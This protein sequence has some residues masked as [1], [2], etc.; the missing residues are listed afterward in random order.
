[1]NITYRIFY[2]FRKIFIIPVSLFL[3]FSY[4]PTVFADAE[5]AQKMGIAVLDFK[6]S[7]VAASESSFVSD[8]FRGALVTA[9]AFRLIDKSNMD[10]VLS[11]Q[12]FQQTGCTSQECAVQMGKLLNVKAMVTGTFGLFLGDYVISI[13]MVDVETGEI[14]YS[15]NKRCK[16]P[17]Q[18]QS[19]VEEMAGNMVA[20]RTGKAV[21]KPA[22]KE[23]APAPEPEPEPQPVY[24]PPVEK[25]VYTPKSTVTKIDGNQVNINLGKKENLRK[26]D[27]LQIYAV[28]QQIK[29]PI[30]GQ[31][32][33]E[34]KDSIAKIK[35]TYLEDYASIGSVISLKPGY[36]LEVGQEVRIPGSESMIR[37]RLDALVDIPAFTTPFFKNPN[38]IYPEYQS[39]LDLNLPVLK[40]SYGRFANNFFVTS[41]RQPMPRYLM[42]SLNSKNFELGFGPA[43][44]TKIGYCGALRFGN[45]ETI[46]GGLDIR[47]WAGNAD[48]TG[49]DY[50]LAA[51]HDRQVKVVATLGGLLTKTA[52]M[53][54]RG[55]MDTGSHN[56]WGESI[57]VPNIGALGLDSI[58]E[59][60]YGLIIDWLVL[61][62][63]EVSIRFGYGL[64]AYIGYWNY[65]GGLSQKQDFMTMLGLAGL[66]INITRNI[67]IGADFEAEL[68]PMLLTDGGGFSPC[69]RTKVDI[70]F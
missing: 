17:G 67:S 68:N 52:G 19:V 6:P 13:G 47:G 2:M 18:I 66:S 38:Y 46:I 22:V 31:V 58:T 9:K 44:Q 10:K 65:T 51:V 23:V 36:K 56:Y 14:V 4:T 29:S 57:S 41:W 59:S 43:L 33:K 54:I 8:F 48:M 40:F 24:T 53:Y 32:I 45:L 39:Q 12:G 61:P 35:L 60:R 5:P 21:S 25:V 15:D 7:G 3:I 20:D 30:T 49:M 55:K 16:D 62:V 34:K 37:F 64:Y 42:V 26:N 28:V 50:S 69:L 70:G 63:R 1:M 11:E 27:V